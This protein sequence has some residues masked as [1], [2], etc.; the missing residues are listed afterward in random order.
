MPHAS[1][2]GPVAVRAA[3]VDRLSALDMLHAEGVLLLTVMSG[4]GG[5]GVF[6]TRAP[7]KVCTHVQETPAHSARAGHVNKAA[8][9]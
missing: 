7:Q 6:L 5:G 9:V 8:G 4:V 2:S 1:V 3:A